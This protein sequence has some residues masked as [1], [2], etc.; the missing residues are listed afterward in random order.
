MSALD[1]AFIKAYANMIPQ[2]AGEALA[3]G[4]GEGT[5]SAASAAVAAA[6]SAG[7]GRRIAELPAGPQVIEQIYLSATLYRIDLPAASAP[8]RVAAAPPHFELPP[9]SSPRRSVRR[10]VL[11]LVGGIDLLDTT[12]PVAESEK[13]T[14]PPRRGRSF[15]RLRLP[16]GPQQELPPE[17]IADAPSRESTQPLSAP[18]EGPQS[19]P[20][21]AAPAAPWTA[22]LADSQLADSR[23]IEVHGHWESDSLASAETLIV[24]PDLDDEEWSQTT[25]QVE[26]RLDVPNLPFDTMD[27]EAADREA[28]QSPSPTFR[29]DQPHAERASRP[30]AK[31]GRG[32]EV[33]D[34]AET[35]DRAESARAAG[36]FGEAAEDQDCVDSATERGEESLPANRSERGA[37]ADPAAIAAQQHHVDSEQLDSEE[38]EGSPQAADGSQTA[39]TAAHDASCDP[40]WEV[41]R[42]QWP[43]TVERLMSDKAG[44]FSQGGERL[45]AAVRDGLRTLAVTGSRRGEG[46]TTLALCLARAAAQAGIQAAVID[47]DFARPQLASR[48]GL[49]V[50][51][52]WQDA[53]TGLVPLSEAAVRSLSDGLT[54]LPLEAAS[55]A[56]QLSLADPRVTATLRAAAATFELVIVDLGPLASGED[57]LFPAGE[58]CPFDAAI[59]VRDLRYAST[60]ESEGIGERLYAAGI[61]AVGVAENFVPAEETAAASD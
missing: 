10:S 32:A 6:R 40:G 38:N 15:S 44:Y 14:L 20:D 48:V 1:R 9:R 61:E 55:A 16:A 3:V 33:D 42:F 17:S 27:N 23:C 24:L 19:L 4:G 36:Y 34:Q 37:G 25:P 13:P 29:L 43:V 52:G 53:A 22:N 41:D 31:F 26:L 47:A 2:A 49:E 51:H 56:G 12:A 39:G 57:K 21:A 8:R 18:S 30:H 7:P 35:E 5:A 54:V 50:A 46:R 45:V 59:V 58:K 60:A 28:A 11:K